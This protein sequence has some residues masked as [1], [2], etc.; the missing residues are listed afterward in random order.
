MM[1]L[2]YCNC[3][4]LS[5]PQRQISKPVGVAL[6][7]WVA[8][9]ST[10]IRGEESEGVV[11]DSCTLQRRHD[12]PDGPVHFFN[13]VAN[14]ATW[15]FSTKPS[16]ARVRGVDVVEGYVKIKRLALFGLLIDE[17]CCE[18]NIFCNK[19]VQAHGLLD[20][21]RAVKQWQRY[22]LEGRGGAEMWGVTP[23]RYAHIL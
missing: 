15:C 7:I 21:T 23:K 14:R 22:R 10:V 16:G 6:T 8:E 13:S 1:Q 20:D 19:V 12:L 4:H 11:I 17:I 9:R 3:S 5:S 2:Q 18:L